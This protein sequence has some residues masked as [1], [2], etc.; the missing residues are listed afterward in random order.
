M[1]TRFASL[2]VSTRFYHRRWAMFST[3]LQRGYSCTVNKAR[4]MRFLMLRD[5]FCA[6]GLWKRREKGVDN[7]VRVTVTGKKPKGQSNSFQGRL[8]KLINSFKGRLQI[9]RESVQ[10]P[11]GGSL[12]WGSNR[13]SGRGKGIEGPK[14]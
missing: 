9:M 8:Q 6:H 11:I 14:K 13:S 3:M 7:D 12:S 2:S 10:G 5:Y 4:F 1:R